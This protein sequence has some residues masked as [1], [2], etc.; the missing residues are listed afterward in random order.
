MSLLTQLRHSTTHV[1]PCY[2]PVSRHPKTK[3][4]R[5]DVKCNLRDGAG[6]MPP[7]LQE[8]LYPRRQRLPVLT[9]VASCVQ[10]NVRLFHSSSWNKQPWF[11]ARKMSCHKLRRYSLIGSFFIA[12]LPY[13]GFLWHMQSLPKIQNP[14]TSSHVM[15]LLITRL[16]GRACFKKVQCRP[17]RQLNERLHV[18]TKLCSNLWKSYIALLGSA[19]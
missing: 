18:W 4:R 14:R 2:A 15:T 6:D 11:L 1:A 8:R 19:P 16:L 3:S 13:H 17:C 7:R 9:L 12:Q 5:N 10:I